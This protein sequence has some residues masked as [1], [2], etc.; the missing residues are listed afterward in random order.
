MLTR[1]WLNLVVFVC[2]IALAAITLWQPG[3]MPSPEN[4]RFRQLLDASPHS[5]RIERRAQQTV[6]L[7]KQAD[8]WVLDG[9]LAVAADQPKVFELLRFLDAS[10]ENVLPAQA[11]ELHRFELA[12]PRVRL[13]INSEKFWFGSTHP[14]DG[15]R[16]VLHA[17]T[18]YLVN[19][20]SY[21][22]LIAEPPAYASRALMT[23]DRQIMS[24]TRGEDRLDKAD[25]SLLEHWRAAMAERVQTL[26]D[27]LGERIV[28]QFANGTVVH[29][30]AR[31]AEDSLIL[32]RADL[33]I[34]YVFPASAELSL[35]GSEP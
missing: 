19:D 8:R 23:A 2:V 1:Y 14:L 32:G 3:Q 27:P 13:S 20:T 21:Y 11:E 30:D 33:G 7:S 24:V 18:I 10:A 9:P 12:R 25:S 16:Y 6:A 31:M 4:P 28:V 22:H 35:F 26:S 29:F 17:D 34:E 15:R 5:I